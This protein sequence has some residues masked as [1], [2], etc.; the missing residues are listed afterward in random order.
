[1]TRL[2][3]VS[4]FL[5]GTLIDAVI[6]GEALIFCYCMTRCRSEWLNFLYKGARSFFI[7]IPCLW[8]PLDIFGYNCQAPFPFILVFVLL[9]SIF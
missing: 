9:R 6:G 8:F 5:F 4:F 2:G 1:M 3:N 7:V